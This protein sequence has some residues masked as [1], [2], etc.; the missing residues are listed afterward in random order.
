MSRNVDREVIL[1]FIS[2]AK[3]YLPD[4]TRGIAEFHANPI[5][6]ELLEEPYRYTHTIKGASSMVGLTLLSHISFQLEETLEKLSAGQLL[7]TDEMAMLLHRVVAVLEVY[8]DE[9]AKG[10]V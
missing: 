3:G 4:I 9:A 6:F 2:E 10:A 8:L 1:G 5:A 7:L